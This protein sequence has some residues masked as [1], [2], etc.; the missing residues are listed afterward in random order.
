MQRQDLVGCCDAFL[1]SLCLGVCLDRGGPRRVGVVVGVSW[2]SGAIQ[3]LHHQGLTTNG[4][5]HYPA[6]PSF[7]CSRNLT[8]SFMRFMNVQSCVGGE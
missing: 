7:R 6:S 5:Q 8:L 3:A 1:A 4:V 2:M